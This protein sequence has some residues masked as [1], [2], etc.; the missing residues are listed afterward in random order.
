MRRVAK[1]FTG[2]GWERSLAVE[3]RWGSVRDM[4][5]ATEKEWTEVDGIG[6]G[7][8]KKIKEELE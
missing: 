6:K 7:I 2:I 5:N 4:V 8:A 1:E 3:G